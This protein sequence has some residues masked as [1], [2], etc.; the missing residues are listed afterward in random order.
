MLVGGAQIA[1]VGNIPEISE[2]LCEFVQLL[3]LD[4]LTATP[5]E[6]YR[7]NGTF[8]VGKNGAV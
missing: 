3:L 5:K 7:R 6:G 4:P 8:R 1:V 2:S